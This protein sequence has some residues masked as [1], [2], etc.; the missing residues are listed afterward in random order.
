MNE[1]DQFVKHNLRIKHYVRYTDDFLIVDNDPERLEALLQPIQ[2]F[3]R[4]QLKLELHPNKVEIRGYTKGIDFLGY[5]SFPYFRLLRK[6]TEKRMLRKI[7]R[8]IADYRRNV[9]TK[10]YAEASLNSY[11]GVLSH[12]DAQRLGEKLKNDFWVQINS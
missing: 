5:V 11:M 4:E 7:G 2:D 6:K 12:A 1:C 8:V 3:L 10:E 9:V